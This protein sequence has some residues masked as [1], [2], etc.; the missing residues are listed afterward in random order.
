MEQRTGRHRNDAHDDP[1]IGA[2]APFYAARL[3]DLLTVQ[4][5]RVNSAPLL[6]LGHDARPAAASLLEDCDPTLRQA[7]IEPLS[8]RTH[9]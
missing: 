8:T 1:Q 6:A 4:V 3:I 5:H 7:R 2:K 9:P